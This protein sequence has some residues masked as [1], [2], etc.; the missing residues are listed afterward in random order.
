LTLAFVA[1]VLIVVDR[2]WKKLPPDHPAV[3]QAPTLDG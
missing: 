3:Y 1:L 2:M